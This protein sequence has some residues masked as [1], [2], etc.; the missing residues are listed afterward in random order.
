MADAIIGQSTLG[1]S[2]GYEE[3]LKQARAAGINDEEAS[4]LATIA[5]V[6]TGILYAATAPLSP[7]MK[8]TDAIIGKIKNDY[9]KVALTFYFLK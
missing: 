3:T 4:R 9:I 5:S 8:A 7:Q 2:K 1:F 6:Q